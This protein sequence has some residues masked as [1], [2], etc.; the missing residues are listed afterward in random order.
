MTRDGSQI[1]V[2]DNDNHRIRSIDPATRTVTTIAGN[3][4]AQD[5][6]GEALKASIESPYF[7]AFDEGATEPESRVYITTARSVRCLTLATGTHVAA[8]RTCVL[9]PSL[10]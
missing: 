4:G 2:A 5:T 8:H 3:G 9:S 10:P 6:D 1:L 7:M